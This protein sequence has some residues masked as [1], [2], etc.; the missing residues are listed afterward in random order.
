M[1]IKSIILT[2][3]VIYEIVEQL[4]RRGKK[5]KL[6]HYGHDLEFNITPR[7]QGMGALWL[8][9]HALSFTVHHL[10]NQIQKWS[11]TIDSENGRDWDVSNPIDPLQNLFY[12]PLL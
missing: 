11:I 2:P 3:F 8:I 1:P 7:A 10:S 12:R 5:N 9:N 6:A 4:T